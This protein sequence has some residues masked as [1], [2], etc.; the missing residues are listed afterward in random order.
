MS[1]RAHASP[2]SITEKIGGPNDEP[3]VSFKSTRLVF[4][5]HHALNLREDR[6]EGFVLV[7][8]GVVKIQQ[9]AQCCLKDPALNNASAKIALKKQAT[10][11][12]LKTSHDDG[13]RHSDPL[14]YVHRVLGE[15][16]ASHT[17]RAHFPQLSRPDPVGTVGLVEP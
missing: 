1:C 15:P 6:A 7:V 17:A 8:V 16:G 10:R 4:N 14:P 3:T 5:G 13:V 12:D 11:S 9:V 2:I